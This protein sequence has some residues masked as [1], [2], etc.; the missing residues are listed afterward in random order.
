MSLDG[1]KSDFG[2]NRRFY[3]TEPVG[4]ILALS[5]SGDKMP[6]HGAMETGVVK[7]S[8]DLNAAFKVKGEAIC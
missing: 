7:L 2:W 3:Y 6:C 8:A 5:L 4:C 1:H